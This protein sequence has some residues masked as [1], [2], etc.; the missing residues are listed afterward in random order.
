VLA[1]RF[2]GRR[3]ANLAR[4]AQLRCTLH[5]APNRSAPT[6]IVAMSVA[7]SSLCVIIASRTERAMA[8][9]ARSRIIELPIMRGVADWHLLILGQLG[10]PRLR[11]RRGVWEPR[12]RTTNFLAVS[13]IRPFRI[14]SVYRLLKGPL[15]ALG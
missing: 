11:N 3:A 9:P 6:F 5:N 2:A 10:S 14:F 1:N 8:V 15:G 12:T 7:A 13:E 4:Q